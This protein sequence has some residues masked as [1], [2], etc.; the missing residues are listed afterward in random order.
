MVPDDTDVKDLLI[1]YHRSG[2]TS[3]DTLSDLL[4]TQHDIHIIGINSSTMV[5]C[6]LKKFGLKAS[7][8]TTHTLPTSTKCQLILNELDMDSTSR[9]GPPSIREAI[10][11]HMGVHLIRWVWRNPGIISLHWHHCIESTSVQKCICLTPWGSL[12]IS[13]ALKSGS[14]P[15]WSC[16]VHTTN[17]AVMATTSYQQLASPSGE[18]KMSGQGFG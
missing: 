3:R 17:V 18:Y 12:P 2:I 1:Q 8:A 11:E 16:W 10:R 9:K 6:R 5:A 15:S 4:K 13:H 14:V 7:S